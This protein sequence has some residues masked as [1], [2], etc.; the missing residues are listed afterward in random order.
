MNDP[1]ILESGFTYDKSFIQAYFNEKE[2]EYVASKKESTS[3]D[4]DDDK[5]EDYIKCPGVF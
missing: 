4:D 3:S 2:R 5:L 1:V